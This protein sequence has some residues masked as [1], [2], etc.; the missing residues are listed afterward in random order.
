MSRQFAPGK[1]SGKFFQKKFTV[2]LRFFRTELAVEKI[3]E[4][5][6]HFV[7]VLLNY[8]SYTADE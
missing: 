8:G 5:N 2:Y 1:D 7:S 3:F 4:R 6:A